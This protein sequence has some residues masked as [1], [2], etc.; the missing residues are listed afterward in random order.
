MSSLYD[1]FGFFTVGLFSGIVFCG[2]GCPAFIGVYVS[3]LSEDV[4]QSLII[5]A[6]FN[7]G[8]VAVYLLLA[9]LSVYLGRAVVES[10]GIAPHIV[11]I[12]M[13][14]AIGLVLSFSKPKS[15]CSTGSFS[16]AYRRLL[17]RS[18]FSALLIGAVT[19][20]IPCL[21]FS[22]V[23]AYAVNSSSLA[24]A[25]VAAASFGLGSS[26]A[27]LLVVGALLGLFAKSVSLRIA[28]K[29]IFNRI[30]GVIILLIAFKDIL[31]LL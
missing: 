6:L 4:K 5:T 23:V 2:F 9:F 12:S 11:L 29:A 30:C 22:A 25:M 7:L 21:P 17:S 3:A 19:G 26:I 31:V 28:N 15:N 13:M 27:Y 16:S 18:K 20:L 10:L 1:A 14:V 8:R 24:N